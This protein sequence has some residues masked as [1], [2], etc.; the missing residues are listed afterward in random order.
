MELVEKKSRSLGKW[1]IVASSYLKHTFKSK[2]K[3]NT[4]K[5]SCYNLAEDS[6]LL[7]YC[8]T[9]VIVKLYEK[10]VKCAKN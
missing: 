7:Q 4:R 1:E 2:K 9:K 3:K 5:S 8:K 6:G 10:Y